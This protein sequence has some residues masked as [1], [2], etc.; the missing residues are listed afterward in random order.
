MAVTQH[1]SSAD[2]AL[3]HA[4]QLARD[5]VF[6]T[7]PD[8]LLSSSFIAQDNQTAYL[9]LHALF[10]DIRFAIIL[11]Q[12]ASVARKKL[13]WWAE[14]IQKASNGS[15]EHP[16][17]QI[18][19]EHNVDANFWI[20]MITLIRNGFDLR[21]NEGV[22]ISLERLSELL[23]PVELQLEANLFGMDE[24]Q[25]LSDDASLMLE[26]EAI[27]PLWL[28]RQNSKEWPLSLYGKRLA[29]KNAEQL[30]LLISE[31]WEKFGRS[32]FAMMEDMQGFNIRLKL[33]LFRLGK[34]ASGHKESLLSPYKYHRLRALW[35]AW[36]AAK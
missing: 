27:L 4:E 10:Q 16:Y 13:T 6:S 32:D 14:E 22:D 34:I 7:R 3:R 18:L 28:H 20:Q 5:K 15:A 31:I 26:L 24:V 2:K 23:T 1:H 19:Q 11:I 9:A 30:Q 36:R 35:L 17:T 25:N 12:D 29:G 21:Q 33:A 8:T